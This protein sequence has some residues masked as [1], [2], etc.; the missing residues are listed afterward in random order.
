ME[1]VKIVKETEEKVD[2]PVSANAKAMDDF[3]MNAELVATGIPKTIVNEI[4]M[5][6]SKANLPK[7]EIVLD[8]SL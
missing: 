7:K 4:I 1:T 3:I 2:L 6:A 8:R 5:P